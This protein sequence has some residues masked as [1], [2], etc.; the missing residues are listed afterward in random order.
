MSQVTCC[1]GWAAHGDA[2]AWLSCVEVPVHIIH[3]R[4]PHLMMPVSLFTPQGLLF[5]AYG[6][7]FSI[8]FRRRRHNCL[9]FHIWRMSRVSWDSF[10]GAVCKPSFCLFVFSLVGSSK[11]CFVLIQCHCKKKTIRIW[12][13]GKAGS[14]RA[15]HHGT[16]TE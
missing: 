11:Y 6:L 10:L 7:A 1:V 13:F 9:S 8:E 4:P 16:S 14:G 12:A 5:L 15:K 2:P 3:C